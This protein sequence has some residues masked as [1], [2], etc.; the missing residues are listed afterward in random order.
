MTL[1]T[2]QAFEEVAA[3]IKTLE[4]ENE[5]KYGHLIRYNN[6]INRLENLILKLQKENN[7]WEVKNQ[8]SNLEFVKGNRLICQSKKFQEDFK[9][10]WGHEFGE[11]I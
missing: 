3:K 4:A 10:Q 7:A 2:I 6:E 1:K 11:S 9:K 5:K 8:I